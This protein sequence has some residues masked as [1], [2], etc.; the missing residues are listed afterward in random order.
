MKQAMNVN[1]KWLNIDKVVSEQLCTQCGACAAM[2]PHGVIAIERD[3][4]WRYFPHVVD[5]SLC[6]HRCRS[7]CVDV[8]GGV[9]EDTSLWKRDPIVFDTYEEFV[10]GPII[11]TWVGYATDEGIRERGTSGGVVVGLLVHL[12]DRKLINGV[13][14]V[15][16]NANDPLQHDVKIANTREEIE[17]AWGSKYY[18]M[19]IGAHFGKIIDHRQKYAVV[20]L[21][22]HM[23]SLRLMERKI[24][25]LRDLIVLRIGLVCGYC[26]GFKALVDQAR[27]WGLAD[28][29]TV[30][31]IDYREGKWPGNVRIQARGFDRRTLIYNF[32][33]RLPF[34]TN[35]RCMMCSDLMN[36]TADITVGDAWLRELTARNDEGW[37]VLAARTAQAADL[38]SSAHQQ[39]ALYLEPIDTPTLVR[40]QEKPM[41]YKKNALRVRREFM[42]RFMGCSLPDFDFTRFSN[43]FRTNIWNRTG[44]ILFL[45][46][47][48][49]F[50]ERDRARR[51]MYRLVPRPWIDWYVRSLFLMIAYDGHGSFLIKFLRNKDPSLNCDA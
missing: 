33:T 22:C 34:T 28:M 23:R 16:S 10:T 8:C 37:S 7:L 42:H 26:S 21:G 17:D 40:C 9:H 4:H 29:T 27:E 31:R 13:L 41:R 48:W 32:L 3:A 5:S 18:P 2:C 14:L 47:M 45:L 11:S 35:R 20:L 39:G 24:E 19:P 50:F 49:L 38:V 44:N 36:E 15:G 43:D 30:K 6:V 12:L 51:W 46:T 1:P 25:R